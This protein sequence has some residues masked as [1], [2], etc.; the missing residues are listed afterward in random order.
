[1][2]WVYLINS[3]HSKTLYHTPTNQQNAAGRLTKLR[4]NRPQENKITSRLIHSWNSLHLRGGGPVRRRDNL[5]TFIQN[6]PQRSPWQ[7]TRRHQRFL[8]TSNQGELTSDAGHSRRYFHCKLQLRY[9]LVRVTHCPGNHLLWL[10]YEGHGRLSW[11][12]KPKTEFPLN[13]NNNNINRTSI[14]LKSSGT[15]ALKCNTTKLL[16]IFKARDVQHYRGHHQF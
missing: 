7:R 9:P 10:E 4:W 11:S 3:A 14:A 12:H 5:M 13:N 1:M 2:H 16:N 6:C 15:R 8:I